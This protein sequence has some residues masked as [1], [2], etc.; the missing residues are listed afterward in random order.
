M[1]GAA[2]TIMAQ[3]SHVAGW[4][5]VI[6]R[7]NW[8]LDLDAAT[9]SSRL[10]DSWESG[11][12][13]VSY[14][15]RGSKRQAFMYRFIRSFPWYR[16]RSF[17]CTVQTSGAMKQSH[18]THRSI[19]LMIQLLFFFNSSPALRLEIEELVGANICSKR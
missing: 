18:P 13:S 5:S 15:R 17:A 9:V 7:D 6:G 10:L 12:L 16:S 19:F 4:S 3:S 8:S 11:Q 14:E 2:I 1:F